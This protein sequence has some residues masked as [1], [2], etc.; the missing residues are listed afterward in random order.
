M[1]KIKSLKITGLRGIRQPLKLDLQ[2]KSMILYGDNGSGKSSITDAVE[3]FYHNRIEHLA[4]EEIGL[5]GRNA[6]RNVFLKEKE[7]GKI[8]LEFTESKLDSTKTIFNK[9]GSLDTEHHNQSKTYNDYLE[10]SKK[11]NLLLRQRDMVEFVLASKKEKLD[12]LSKIIGFS[13]VTKVKDILK[14][15]LNSLK[16]E[17]KIENFAGRISRQESLIIELMSQRVVTESQ[18][19][20]AVNKLL[21]PLRLQRKLTRFDELEEILDLIKRPKDAGSIE[22][23][24]FYTRLLDWAA[25]LDT[26]LNEI[27]H[28]YEQYCSQFKK[29]ASDIGKIK[30][31]VLE[32]LLS[33]GV[34]VLREDRAKEDECPLC[35]QP[36]SWKDLLMEL[37]SR[38]A[39]L[40]VIKKEKSGLEENRETLKMNFDH[41][42]RR[43]E[44]FVSDPLSRGDDNRELT[45]IL[46]KMMSGFAA[47]PVQLAVEISNTNKP[48]SFCN[49]RIDRGLIKKISLFCQNKIKELRD[50]KKDD[51]KYDIYSK[52][53]QVKNAFLEI[54]KLKKEKKIIENQAASL[55]I[56]YSEFLKRQ[57]DGIESFF[58]LLSDDIN[59]LY[60]FMNPGEKVEKIELAPIEK[61]DEMVGI[62]LEYEFFKNYE[63]PPQKYLS[64][65][66]LNC[67]GIAFFLT[68]VKAFNNRNR[69]FILDDVI[70]SFDSAHRRRFAELLIEKF[71]D[72][73]VILLTHEKE[74]YDEVKNLLKGKNWHVD[75]LKWKVEK[76]TFIAGSIKK[77]KEKIKEKMAAGELNELSADMGRYLEHFLKHLAFR[78]EVKVR[79]LYNDRNERRACLEILQALKEHLSEYKCEELLNNP[80]TALPSLSLFV[81]DKEAYHM[82]PNAGSE[83]L[84]AF[85]EEIE[86]FRSL[87]LCAS[88][89]YTISL[90]YYDP[91]QKKISCKCGRLNYRWQ[92]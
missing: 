54:K 17:I 53:V 77:F 83:D 11:E 42:T 36:K 48:E 8:E 35:L 25:G 1:N 33:E 22:L 32:Q 37:E 16:K 91:G 44:M 85:W 49:L 45:G 67:L 31:I 2:Q 78:L 64:E 65:S 6:L 70:S 29:I 72:Y 52:I 63:S 69:F 50:G 24:S 89:G 5:G 3:W 18:F 59:D 19:V 21:E 51:Y 26:V 74:W 58:T 92:K 43:L 73:Q 28:L 47:Y 39:E 23:E 75:A 15:T 34:R 87:F 62:T 7:R 66:H 76:G 12:F 55:D 27:E 40:E 13:E 4:G 14:R 38:L 30:K 79:F 60:L 84:S 68:S 82:Q 61:N 10:E 86:N 57:E 41:V 9:N 71:S 90:T 56:L 80:V 88:C 20:A 81:E 46:N